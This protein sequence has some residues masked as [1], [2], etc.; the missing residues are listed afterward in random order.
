MK[1]SDCQNEKNTVKYTRRKKES[2]W[3]EHMK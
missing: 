2:K 3:E 1:E